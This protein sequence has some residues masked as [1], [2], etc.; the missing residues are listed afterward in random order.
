MAYE[1]PGIEQ[2]TQPTRKDCWL[3]SAIMIMSNQVKRLAW[4]LDEPFFRAYQPVAKV[5]SSREGVKRR[6]LRADECLNE[7]VVGRLLTASLSSEQPLPQL[8]RQ[9]VPR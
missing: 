7:L 8:F 1:V 3:T 4:R 9:L 2:L 5:A 6:R